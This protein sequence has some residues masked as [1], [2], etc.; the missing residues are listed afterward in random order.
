MRLFFI[1]SFINVFFFFFNSHLGHIGLYIVLSPPAEKS[2]KFGSLISSSMI[3]LR[4]NFKFNP[5]VVFY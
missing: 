1:I 4:F 5:C 2:V 3:A